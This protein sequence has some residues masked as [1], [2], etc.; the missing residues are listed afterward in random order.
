M[1]LK[2]IFE[3]GQVDFVLIPENREESTLLNNIQ[4]DYDFHMYK[5]YNINSIDGKVNNV[6]ITMTPK[7]QETDAT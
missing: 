2:A 7:Q 6:K 4:E 3:V 1:K 5:Y